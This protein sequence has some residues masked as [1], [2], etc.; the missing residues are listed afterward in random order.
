MTY[1]KYSSTT[2]WYSDHVSS[3]L[4]TASVPTYTAGNAMLYPIEIYDNGSIQSIGVVKQNTSNRTGL[5]L[6]GAVYNVASDGRPGTVLSDFG[7]FSLA[8]AGTGIFSVSGTAAVVKGTYYIAIKCDNIG[9]AGTQPQIWRNNIHR[10]GAHP[11]TGYSGVQATDFTTTNVG[12]Y[13]FHGAYYYTGLGAGAYPDLSATAWAAAS[14]G[15][16]PMAVYR[17]SASTE[18]GEGWGWADSETWK[19]VA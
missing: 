14:H 9:S 4:L 11:P 18:S 10:D 1:P 19:V 8:S 16:N 7:Q 12:T 13:T 2:R 15:F 6:R 17:Y 3:N 5:L